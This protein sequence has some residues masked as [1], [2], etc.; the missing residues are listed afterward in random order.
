MAVSGA[1]ALAVSLAVEAIV[2]RDRSKKSIVVRIEPQMAVRSPGR[3]VPGVVP[4]DRPD[5]RATPK[6][7]WGIHWY[8]SHGHFVGDNFIYT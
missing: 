8:P 2:A 7:R 1:H 6:S 4:G 3:E 5:G